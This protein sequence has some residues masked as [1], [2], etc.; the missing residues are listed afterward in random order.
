MSVS[1]FCVP[2]KLEPPDQAVFLSIFIYLNPSMTNAVISW[3]RL[4]RL[5]MLQ[6]T[7]MKT[8]LI[9]H[10]AASCSPSVVVTYMGKFYKNVAP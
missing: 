6:C 3:K 7:V 1:V 5:I 4:L 8:P 10:Y 2:C 9:C